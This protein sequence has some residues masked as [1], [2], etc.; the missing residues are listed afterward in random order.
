M[1]IDKPAD[2]RSKLEEAFAIPQPTIIDVI[3]SEDE[4]VPPRAKASGVYG[5]QAQ[6]DPAVFSAVSPYRG[7]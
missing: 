3:V 7:H 5:P 6:A 4:R 2:L 1:R